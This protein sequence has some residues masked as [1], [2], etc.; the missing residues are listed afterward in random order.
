MDIPKAKNSVNTNVFGASEAENNGIYSV[1][2]PL[3][4]RITVF[5]MFFGVGLAKAVVFFHAKGAKTL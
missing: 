5:A 3:V 2:L 4:A 1:F